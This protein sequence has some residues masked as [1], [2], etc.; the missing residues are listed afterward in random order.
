MLPAGSKVVGFIPTRNADRAKAFFVDT[1]GLRFVSDDSFAVVLESSGVMI[2]VARVP[3]YTPHMFTIFGWE[4][5]DIGQAVTALQGRGVT[6]ER[7]PFMP[8]E[9]PPVW[10][11]PGGAAKVAWF[12]DPDGNVLSL[13]QHS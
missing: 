10:N 9:G 2:R 8:K 5:M 7:Y 6:F 11:A 1:L 12:K 4:V 13:S 3:E